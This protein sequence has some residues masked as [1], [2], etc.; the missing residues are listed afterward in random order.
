MNYDIDKLKRLKVYEF[1]DYLHYIWKHIKLPQ[2]TRT[3]CE[4]AE[5]MQYGPEKLMIQAFR[6]VGKSFIAGAFIDWGF[7]QNI[8]LR[9]LILSATKMKADENAKFT[10][11]LIYTVPL[12]DDMIPRDRNRES[13][14]AFDVNGSAT[15]QA[16]SVKSV[17][18][19]G[20]ITGSRADIILADDIEIPKN[21]F[22][23]N[24]RHKLSEQIKELGGAILKPLP[25]S[26]II[27]L[28]TPQVEDTVYGKLPERGYSI[29]V[30][31]SE[32]PKKTHIYFGR[33]APSVT[34]MIAA[35]KPA[36]TPVDPER[37]DA[38]ELVKRKAEY[39]ATGY[40]LQF[41]LDTSPKDLEAHPLKL[42]D[43]MVYDLETTMTHVKF[44][45]GRE[46]NNRSTA[47]EDLQAAGFDGDCYYK[48]VYTSDE[49]SEYG[50]SIMYIDPSGRGRDETA[51]AIVKQ[52]YGQLFLL[53]VGGFKDGYGP[54][55]L[56]ALAKAAHA[57]QV[58]QIFLEDNFGDGMFT[59]MFTPV[60]LK[61]H[62]C[63]VEGETVHGQKELRIIDTLKPVI[64]NH[65]LI[66]S[67]KVIEDDLQWPSIKTLR[68]PSPTNSPTSRETKAA[69]STRTDLKP[70]P[71]QC[72]ST[73]RLWRVTLTKLTRNTRN[74]WP[75]MNC[76]SSWMV[77]SSMI[78]VMKTTT[79]TANG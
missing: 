78:R 16:P 32:V 75:P 52:L 9:N 20:Q 76:R 30:W 22:T 56:Q 25:T 6:G 67:R 47:I 23:Q 10:Q 62:L 27:F 69:S 48:P 31:P 1:K 55:T 33:L 43:L 68:S 61:I 60:V 54:E 8:N 11:D 24:L 63:G 21:S 3:Q 45:W 57:H 29:R 70:S 50:S 2:P 65:K 49:M 17:G 12:F 36:G 19:T 41:M 15:D 73:S 72:V 74:R 46:T 4:I 58:K 71:A 42:K 13:A 64:D 77:S 53:E 7:L 40:P 5:Y 59:Q 79:T 14:I 35:G 26:R 39:G 44:V 51:Y 28:G 38:G 18:I 34:D 66:V 37:F